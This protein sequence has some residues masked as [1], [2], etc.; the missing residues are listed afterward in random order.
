M[1]SYLASECLYN[2][3]EA[4]RFHSF[5]A[6]L[7]HMVAILV[8]HTFQNIAIQL[9]NDQLLLVKGDGFEGLL[10]NSAAVHLKRQWLH[11]RPQLAHQLGLLLCRAK[12]KELL[13]H[14]VA[15]HV[16]H[17][18]VGSDE[19]LLE[20]ELLLPRSSSL[21]LLLDEP[22]AML[23]LRELHHVVGQLSQLE[24]GVPVVPEVLKQPAPVAVLVNTARAGPRLASGY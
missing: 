23:V 5:N 16:G 11:M 8:L 17:E 4:G 20:D 14:I 21:Q 3:L 10:D 1:Q 6:L 19:N 24:V 18:L 15:K 9:L 12:L 22:R 7:D 2:E 13:D